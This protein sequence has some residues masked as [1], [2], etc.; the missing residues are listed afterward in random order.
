ME[1][2]VDSFGEFS[3]EAAI[4]EVNRYFLRNLS[5]IQLLVSEKV[6]LHLKSLR[7]LPD[8]ENFGAAVLLLGFKISDRLVNHEGGNI[9]L[10]VSI[11]LCC[12]PQSL[13]LV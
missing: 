10:L 2:I 13:V 3:A 11:L 1:S 12:L 8:S 9:V 5:G 7:S 4:L 6:R